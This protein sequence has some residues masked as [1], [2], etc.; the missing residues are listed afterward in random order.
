MKNKNKTLKIV[1]LVIFVGF[2]GVFVGTQFVNQGSTDETVER[3]GSIS[4][5]VV[6][7]EAGNLTAMNS[8]DRWLRDRELLQEVLDEAVRDGTRGQILGV[9]AERVEEVGDA[10]C[11]APYHRD[12][13]AGHYIKHEG[14]L[15][16]VDTA[17]NDTAT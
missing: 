5:V 8:T 16:V 15:I 10:V 4:A 3:K 7:E 12:P 9:Q 14:E 1:A 6:S 13:V 11:R 2:S 17:I